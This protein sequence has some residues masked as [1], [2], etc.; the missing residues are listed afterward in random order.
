LSSHCNCQ[1]LLA[2]LCSCLFSHELW[3]RKMDLKMDLEM[4]LE[5]T[6]N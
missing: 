4:D 1:R 3:D 6:Q 2:S 5:W